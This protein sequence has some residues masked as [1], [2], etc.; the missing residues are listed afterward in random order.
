MCIKQNRG[1]NRRYESKKKTDPAYKNK[2]F[3]LA[4]KRAAI[5]QNVD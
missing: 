4:F 3:C 2:L 1:R 5:N